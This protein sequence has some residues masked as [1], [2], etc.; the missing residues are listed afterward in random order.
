MA[1]GS[2]MDPWDDLRRGSSNPRPT[3]ALVQWITFSITVRGGSAGHA[4]AVDCAPETRVGTEPRFT[5]KPHVISTGAVFG[6]DARDIVVNMDGS[7]LTVP[8]FGAGRFRERK[9]R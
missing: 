1:H 8:E 5:T 9:R 3:S 7:W 6:L 2:G 4:H